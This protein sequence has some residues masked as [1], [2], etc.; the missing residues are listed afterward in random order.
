MKWSLLRLTDAFA[1]PQPEPRR[2]PD[3]PALETRLPHRA[4]ALRALRQLAR[5]HYLVI[6]GKSALGIRLAGVPDIVHLA[7]DLI[8]R[9]LV[10]RVD[11]PE[12][13]APCYTLSEAGRDTLR[14][15][16]AWWRAMN[17]VQRLVVE[18]TG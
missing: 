17:P 12:C 1:S 8:E 7:D 11:V 2:A 18:F 9:G 3:R 5:G 6:G 13:G 14:R 10:D 16:E 15:G 4:L